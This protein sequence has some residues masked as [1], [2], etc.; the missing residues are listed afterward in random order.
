[1]CNKNDAS[2]FFGS[3][4]FRAI[5]LGPAKKYLRTPVVRNSNERI[6]KTFW[7]L[8]L[9]FF[10]VNVRSRLVLVDIS[11]MLRT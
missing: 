6:F 4:G 2:Q 9:R 7:E 1:M 5:F 8:D 11:R 10:V 3:R